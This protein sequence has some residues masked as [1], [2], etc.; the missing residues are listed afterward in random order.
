MLAL[1]GEVDMASAPLLDER[2]AAVVAD[3]RCEVVVDVAEVTFIDAAGLRVLLQ[4]GQR[5]AVDGRRLT[6][7]APSPFVRRLL[8]ITGL[9][10]ELCV[11]G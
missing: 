4:A 1:R 8:D 9:G 7:R 3:D 5:L 10:C 2:L 11:E 6:L